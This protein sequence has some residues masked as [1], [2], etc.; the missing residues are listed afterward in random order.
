MSAVARSEFTICLA[1]DVM[2]GRGIDQAFAHPS[3]P[4]L[5]EPWVRDAR[6]Y[7]RLAERTSGP[8]PAPI[9]PEYVWGEALDEL[10]RAAPDLRIVNLETALASGGAPDPDKGIHYRMHPANVGCLSAARLDCCVL[11]NNHVMDWGR[12]GL[13]ETL[14]TLERAGLR[15]AGAGSDAEAA[16]A[17]AALPLPDCTRLLVFAL[18]TGSAGLPLSWAAGAG[19][20]GVALLAEPDAAAAERLAARIAAQRRPGDRVLVSVHWGGN[21]VRQVPDG[22][23]AFARRLIDAGA[24]DVVHGHSSHHP[25]PVERYR[26]RLILYGCGD[27]INDYEGIGPHGDLR[28]DL[29]CLYLATFD[30]A[31]GRLRALRIVPYHLRRMRLTRPEAH[32]LRWLEEQLAPPGTPWRCTLDVDPAGGWRLQPA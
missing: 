3:S 24:A 10:A 6:D 13:L 27:L 2:T 19:R 16:F 30:A 25:L 21:W 29:G 8:V 15:H 22:H 26:D 18:G 14:A 1:G 23:R 31:D 7:L 17:P 9:P 32:D 5:H 28:S 4:E 20:A 11:A 12:E